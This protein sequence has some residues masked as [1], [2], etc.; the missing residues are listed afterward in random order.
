MLKNLKIHSVQAVI[1][2]SPF[3]SIKA[4]RKSKGGIANTFVGITLYDKE[5]NDIYIPNLK[6]NK[7][8]ILFKKNYSKQ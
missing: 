7:I 8:E 6:L 3:I 1:F 4:E 2:E 5:G